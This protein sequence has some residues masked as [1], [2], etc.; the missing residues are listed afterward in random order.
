MQNL[1]LH[2]IAAKW[3]CEIALHL[4]KETYESKELLFA[5]PE[6]KL[7]FCVLFNKKVRVII[8]PKGIPPAA[9]GWI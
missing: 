1:F 3:L 6:V 5:H 2:P 8:G 7:G 9:M 4:A